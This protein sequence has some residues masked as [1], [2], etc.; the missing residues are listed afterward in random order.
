MYQADS[1]EM[2]AGR[3]KGLV[4]Q[5]ER[6]RVRLTQVVGLVQQKC[7]CN[8]VLIALML[9]VTEFDSIKNISKMYKIVSK[10]DCHKFVDF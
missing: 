8:D 9:H 3:L 1:T 10:S 6:G 5:V 4:M 2:T 7:C